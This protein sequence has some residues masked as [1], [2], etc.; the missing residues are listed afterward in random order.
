M[1][2]PFYFGDVWGSF[3]KGISTSVVLMP[4]VQNSSFIIKFIYKSNFSC[5]IDLHRPSV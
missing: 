5:F 2:V 1:D 3:E 4:L